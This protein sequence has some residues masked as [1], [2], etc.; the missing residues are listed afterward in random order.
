M[1]AISW[2]VRYVRARAAL[3]R[4]CIATVSRVDVATAA[5]IA[6]RSETAR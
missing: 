6:P 1:P 5:S 4:S 2:A 3:M